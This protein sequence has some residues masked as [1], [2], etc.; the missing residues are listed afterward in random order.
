MRTEPSPFRTAIT[1]VTK[2]LGTMQIQTASQTAVFKTMLAGAGTHSLTAVFGGINTAGTSV[3]PAQT[4]T[5]TGTY[6]TTTA[7][8]STGMEGNYTLTATVTGYGNPTPT[9]NVTFQRH[10]RRN[11]YRNRG[12]QP[13]FALREYHSADLHAE[14]NTSVCLCH[15][16]GRLQRRR[17]SGHSS[18]QYGFD[19]GTQHTSG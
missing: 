13:G 4:V 10:N 19:S 14:W 16:H 6:A 11:I 8:T 1:G 7:L 5:L 12:S 2:V 9:G 17:H 15:S 18:N 3:S